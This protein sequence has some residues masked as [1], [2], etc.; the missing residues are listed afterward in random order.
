MTSRRLSY[1][2]VSNDTTQLAVGH[3]SVRLY[4]TYICFLTN[5]YFFQWSWLK[6]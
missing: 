6:F 5:V 4:S 1:V 2:Q 3:V